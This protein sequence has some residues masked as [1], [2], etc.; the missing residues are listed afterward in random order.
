M[1]RQ[2]SYTNGF[3]YRLRSDAPLYQ[4]S[5]SEIKADL[6]KLDF[7]IPSR[8]YSDV[9]IPE[10][11]LPKKRAAPVEDLEYVIDGLVKLMT[12]KPKEV[13]KKIAPVIEKKTDIPVQPINAFI[14]MMPYFSL[15]NP[16]LMRDSTIMQNPFHYQPFPYQ[17]VI[18]IKSSADL[19]LR[20]ARYIQTQKINC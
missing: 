1:S 4:A 3:T 2:R 8:K 11:P 5:D 7:T 16:F 10:T 15:Q 20:A 12:A 18:Q 6:K 19:H 17:A 14:A 13:K 9:I